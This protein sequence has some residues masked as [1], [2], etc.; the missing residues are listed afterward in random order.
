MITSMNDADSLL[1]V[2]V[3]SVT[4][5]A[6]LFDIVDGSYRFLA[7]GTAPTTVGAPFRDVSE[8]VR[9]ALDHLQSISGR[10]IV[11]A[12]ERLIMPSSA[13]GSGVDTFAAVVSAGRL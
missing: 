11:G 3:G 6:L 4:T 8:G 5:R 7:A 13:D 10:T 9:I 12:D 2:D 1:V